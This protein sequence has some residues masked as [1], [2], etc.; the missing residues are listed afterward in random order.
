MSNASDI[1]KHFSRPGDDDD[2]NAR[3]TRVW[4]IDNRAVATDGMCIASTHVKSLE[5]PDLS[6]D[7][8]QFAREII[9][10]V[11]EYSVHSSTVPREQIDEW[12]GEYEPELDGTRAGTIW[13]VPFDRNMV[14]KALKYLFVD[15]V[16]ITVELFDPDDQLDVMGD[17]TR[18][19]L[20]LTCDDLAFVL[21]RVRTPDDDV[22][23]L[24]PIDDLLEGGEDAFESVLNK[25]I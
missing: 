24:M 6:T 13:G 11:E 14:A 8:P 17:N 15:D 22:K 1:L 16:D 10:Y 19:G 20:R 5:L 4:R 12:A 7:F 9:Q 23:E 21:A 18:C 2:E 3:M 25:L